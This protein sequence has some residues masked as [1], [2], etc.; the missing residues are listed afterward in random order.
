MASVQRTG[1][2]DQTD[3]TDHILR[4]ASSLS[5]N[6]EQNVSRAEKRKTLMANVLNK[7]A[8]NSRYKGANGRT[9]SVNEYG[10]IQGNEQFDAMY[11][12]GKSDLSQG[13]YTKLSREVFNK[14]NANMLNQME[15]GK[16]AELANVI[17][18][19]NSV[20]DSKAAKGE[21]G[22]VLTDNADDAQKKVSG[23]TSQDIDNTIEL[24]QKLHDQSKSWD[25][26]DGEKVNAAFDEIMAGQDE[27][28]LKKWESV[29]QNTK[30]N[31]DAKKIAFVN[32]IKT[33]REQKA[34]DAN[35][36]KQ[37]NAAKD[38][39]KSTIRNSDVSQ[40][41]IGVGGKKQINEGINIARSV[42]DSELDVITGVTK[43]EGQQRL[44]DEIQTDINTLTLLENLQDAGNVMSGSTTNAFRDLKGMRERFLAQ[45][46]S[47]G[48][49][50]GMKLEKGKLKA[51]GGSASINHR[52]G[53][54]NSTNINLINKGGNTK[55]EST[56]NS[57]GGNA[58]RKVKEFIITDRN[59]NEIGTTT[60]YADDSTLS[61]DSP[62]IPI[63][64][65]DKFQSKDVVPYIDH[66]IAQKLGLD[67][68]H[69][70]KKRRNTGE[71]LYIIETDIGT[72]VENG[73]S[74][75][76]YTWDVTL[77]AGVDY[78]KVMSALG[79]NVVTS[80][81]GVDKY[82]TEQDYK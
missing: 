19:Q 23:N 72:F 61:N 67:T 39:V 12:G 51:A 10:A 69:A 30:I 57:N 28:E 13:G 52:L 21:P 2:I 8:N 43:T 35:W 7:L 82:K 36:D 9:A 11:K 73:S 37:V 64:S 29:Q 14:E 54:L 59:G 32:L 16:K 70:K 62:Y 38:G 79:E 18:A 20:I 75:T 27:E 5:S 76:G 25:T 60:A 66:N 80:K 22:L 81:A 26:S 45:W 63:R 46:N 15:A 58:K 40:E 4:L 50:S 31:E 24:R 68:L 3:K 53:A 42:N 17:N 71:E 65:L 34:N 77:K 48:P 44:N 74:K 47:A 49:T 1:Y 33:E 56:G 78:Q 55:A 41:K 6:L